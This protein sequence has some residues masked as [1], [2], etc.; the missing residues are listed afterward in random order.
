MCWPERHSAL[1]LWKMHHIRPRP[2]CIPRFHLPLKRYPWRLVVSE[3]HLDHRWGTL[4][5]AGHLRVE[6]PKRF[7]SGSWASVGGTAQARWRLARTGEWAAGAGLRR[8]AGPRAASGGGIQRQKRA[9][10]LFIWDLS[11]IASHARTPGNKSRQVAGNGHVDRRD[12]QLRQRPRDPNVDAARGPRGGNRL[13]RPPKAILRAQ[14]SRAPQPARQ[15]MY[16][17]E[18]QKRQPAAQP[19]ADYSRLHRPPAWQVDGLSRP[20]HPRQR[21]HHLHHA[22]PGVR[23]PRARC[24]G[25]NVQDWSLEHGEWRG[26]LLSSNGAAAGT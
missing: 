1:N 23:R 4:G 8:E 20:E 15:R 26:R 19:R 18:A 11:P 2:R 22:Q 25:A 7:G 3:G 9:T 16:A 24:D 6:L 5:P 17:E 12:E 10:P 21:S 13:R 14:A